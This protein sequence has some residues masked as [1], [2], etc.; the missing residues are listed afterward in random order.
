MHMIDSL[1]WQELYFISWRPDWFW[2]L[3]QSWI[4]APKF[5]FSNCYSAINL[6]DCEQQVHIALMFSK[7]LF[8]NL[9]DIHSWLL[10]WL[11]LSGITC[12]L[13][14]RKLEKYFQWYQ[15]F[16]LHRYADDKFQQSFRIAL[17][18]SSTFS[19]KQVCWF[20]KRIQA[21]Y[22]LSLP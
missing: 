1:T 14:H 17:G 20:A 22:H 21:S 3:I 16:L 19:W 18:K 6:L 12:I 13:W 7:T 10:V 8:G 15:L 11:K 2:E 4:P 9:H 5:P